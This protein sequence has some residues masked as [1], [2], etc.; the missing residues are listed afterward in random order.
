MRNLRNIKYETWTSPD[1]FSVRSIT[2]TAWDTSTDSAIVAYG[3]SEH[4]TL[5]EL[6]RVNKKG[7]KNEHTVI[8]S[9]DAPCPNPDLACDEILSLYY[10]GDSQTACLVLAGGDIV[11]V[12]E[13]PLP[14][15]DRIE[16]V[17]SVDAGI[18]AARWSPDEEL[19]AITTKAD[20][21]VFMSRSFEGIM[22]VTMTAEDQKASNHVN[23]GW[24]KKETQFKGRGAN[25]LRDPTMPE[26]VDEGLLSPN[27]KKD[28]TISWR[29]DGAFVA[30]STVQEG[31]RRLIRVYSREGVLDS[32]S[33]PVDNLEGALSWRPAG[34][35]MAGVQR[36]NDRIDIVFFE[37]NGLRHGQFSLR[38]TPEE[39]ETFG[40]NISLAWNSDSSVLAVIFEDRVQFWTT[41]NYHWYLKQEIA[42]KTTFANSL[43]WHQE[44][45]LRMIVASADGI[46]IVEYI[47][48]VARSSTLPPHDYGAVAVIDGK[49]IK[50]T[51]LRSANVPPPM[52]HY[53]LPI[54]E[55]TI[56]VAFNADTSRIAV[57][58]QSGIEV[59]EWEVSGTASSVPTINGRFTFEKDSES[60]YLHTSFD[61]D[62]NILVLRRSLHDGASAISFHGF[63]SET[64][65]MVET[66]PQ[67]NEPAIAL[68]SFERDDKNHAFIQG[69]SGDV[70]SA[71][72]TDAS[73]SHCKLPAFFPWVEI[74]Q[75][76]EDVIAF[77]LSPNGHLY[78]NSRCLAKNCTSFLTTPLHLIFT[79]TTH[80][81]KFVHITDV[82]E[83]EVPNDDPEKDERCRALERG[84]RLV[85][86]MPTSLSLVLQMPRG[87]LETIWPRAMV[88]AGIRKLIAEKNYKRAFSHCRTQRV[89][90]NLLYDY[91][92]EQFLANVG[93]FVDQVKKITYIDLFLSSLREEDVTQTLYKDTRVL[94]PSGT[95]PN[96]N[97]QSLAPPAPTTSSKVNRVCD[98]MLSV[99]SSRQSTNLKNIITA[100]LCKSPPALDDGLK[101]VALLMAT[102][103]SMADK[104]VEHICFLADVNKLYEHA[105]GLYNLDLALLVA[106]QSQKDP[107]EYLPFL[108][109]LQE[110][111][112][113]RRQFSIDDHLGRH[114]KALTS[115]RDSS[116]ADET[117]EIDAYI[118][119]HALYKPALTLY[120]YVPARLS[121]ITHLYAVHLEAKSQYHAAAL[122]YESL[123]LY[124]EASHCY[125]LASPSYWREAL[126]C[127]SLT[128]PT[129]SALSSLAESLADSL[130]EIKSYFDAATIHATYLGSPT[131]AAR[132][133]CKGSYFAAAFELATSPI[134]P[135]PELLEL[136]GV[137]DTGLTDSL[138]VTTELLA[139]C[140]GQLNAQV[141]RIRE[142]RERA[143]ADPLAFYEG[144]ASKGDAD[145]PD[146]ISV[147]ASGVSTSA[148]LFTRYTG[149]QSL[150]TAATGASRVTSKNRRREERK[151][152]RGK[153]GS[154]YEEEYLVASVGR[155]IERAES[156]REEIQRL[157]EGLVR[158]GMRE[159]ALAVEALGAE[160]VQMCK[161]A[162]KEVYGQAEE[163]KEVEEGEVD[164]NGYRPIGGDAVLAESM[165]AS[166]R[167]KVAPV[168][169]EFKKLSLLGV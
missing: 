114:A 72:A 79:T 156:T 23:V 69:P 160:V 150:G 128:S 78:A 154:V 99:L 57:L 15:E 163:A 148:S 95:G 47:F 97:G 118:V 146:D 98:A 22:D 104:A 87:N 145:I 129:P 80:M 44:K 135:C 86:A 17:G 138:G 54:K 93:L 37:R 132:L 35:L 73:L 48:T 149:R 137:I 166:Q 16:I 30:I 42:T 142:L 83:L 49:S 19:L 136:N 158:R 58:H 121:E 155:L 81:L 11:V 94:K 40:K 85:T 56:D 134:R 113:L 67:S 68:S 31:V 24:G 75:H 108:Q 159:G 125:H 76:G 162:V 92:P 28:A 91:Q 60:S 59:Y 152:A 74:I 8:T 168:I 143:L 140:K 165:E 105:L 77:G 117:A 167:A 133:F 64:G 124:A 119:K 144:E 55:N 21:V 7:N 147:A 116:P 111:P 5:V 153:K 51:P 102:D 88:L 3:P 126:F 4:D 120:R 82:Q 65:R 52:A 71:D 96:A 61:S 26:K 50:L 127:L 62:G 9:W 29:G 89:D 39:M 157:V 100:H 10:F 107:R 164:E 151:R 32:V 12:R 45:V 122:A 90:M 115:L 53:E 36:F 63:D 141:P 18:T 14:G 70:H 109:K 33:E 103:Q 112:V 25:A 20:T 1:E 106:Q 161:D 101:V 41:G 38:L 169:G 130:A 46:N 84:S 6:V 13:E 34:N 66:K 2:A 131:T 27:D 123:R 139:E 43:V 110:M